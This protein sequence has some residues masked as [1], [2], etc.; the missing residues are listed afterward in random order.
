MKKPKPQMGNRGKTR[1][2]NRAA[3][4]IRPLKIPELLFEEDEGPGESVA[5]PATKSSALK[6][7][8][9]SISP[10]ESSYTTAR[11]LLMSRDPHS[12]YAH[13]DLTAHQKNQFWSAANPESLVLNVH[14]DQVD[15]PLSATID[16]PPGS[17]HAFVH[18][19]D[20]GARYVGQLGHADENGAWVPIATSLPVVTPPESVSPDRSVQFGR[21][22]AP[23]DRPAS[24][25][26][27]LGLI[28]RESLSSESQAATKAAPVLVPPPSVSW[29]P[30]L[31]EGGER[32]SEAPSY[33]LPDFSIPCAGT[34]Q[35]RVGDVT[36]FENPGSID[37]EKLLR[38][39]FEQLS[40]GDSSALG[41][42]PSELPNFFLKV[43]TEL[44][45]Q[46]ATHPNA[47]VSVCGSPVELQPDGSFSCQY[48]LPDGHL[49]LDVRAL[50][51]EGESR[52]V[53]LKIS[54]QAT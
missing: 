54:R 32:T 29:I 34:E 20:A 5:K 45:V 39:T 37:L 17:T 47:Q 24:V 9:E 27:R 10:S 43:R 28:E 22:P 18:L 1:R 31:P 51:V 30:S 36:S 44:I 6:H 19:A 14:R 26:S 50:S 16:V 49:S 40:V 8:G 35:P 46:G 38:L 2:S 25:S 12:V 3:E 41:E 7:P 48:V 42:I 52:E 4:S 33:E 13:W 53:T 21:M 15:G 23:V 11:L